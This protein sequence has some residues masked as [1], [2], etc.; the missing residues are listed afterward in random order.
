MKSP[1]KLPGS[2]RFS[3]VRLWLGA[4]L[5]FLG[6][7]LAGAAS[8]IIDDFAYSSTNAARQAWKGSP[9]VTVG[10][11]GQWGN[12][13]VMLL[14]CDFA[15]RASRCFWDRTVSLDLSGYTTFDLQIYAPDPSAISSFTLY[16][17]SGAGWYSGGATL[18]G[19][20]WQTLRFSRSD[21]LTEGT[22]SGWGAIDGIRLSPWKGAG[23]DTYL[24]VRQ[25][26]AFTPPVMIVR[27][28]ES[29]NMEVVD[30]TI[31]RHVT[32]LGGYN[33]DC[34]VVSRAD[35]E[36]GLLNG[37]KLAILPYNENISNLEW[38]NLETFVSGGGKLMVYYL[39]PA[40]MQTL[41]GVRS[42]GWTPGDYAAWVF[43]DPSIAGLPSRVEQASWNITR[44]APN[45]TLNSRVTALWYNSNG[46]STG[47]AAWLTS[48]HGFFCTHVL[49]GDDVDQKS[50]ALLCLISH[51]L[52]E[53]WK[54]AASGAIAEI[55]KVGPYQTYLEASGDIRQNA[56]RRLRERP[57]AEQ[58]SLVTSRLGAALSFEASTNY[59]AAIKAAKEARAALREA[60]YLSLR[61][62]APEFRA[63]WEHHATGPYP[64][65]WPAAIENLATNGFTAV[66]PNMLWGGLAHYASAV[67]PRSTEF[68]NYGDQIAACVNA[69]HARGVE[70]HV[71]KVNWN[72]SGAPQSFIN[73]LRAA[74]RTQVSRDGSDIDWLCPSHP[75]NQALELASMLEVVRNYDVDG[76]H[77]DYIR[78]PDSTACYCPGCR[79]RFQ[80]Q[81]GLAVTNW[82]QD[83]LAS[84]SLRTTFLN[85]RRQQITHLVASVHAQAK[86]AK[87]NVKISAAVFP[88]A[89][90]A[91][92]EVGQDWRTWIDQGLV[93]FLCP[94][95]YTTS[96]AGFTNLVSQQLG[97]AAGRI[98]VY[99]GI[100]AFILDTDGTLVQIQETRKFKTGGF[101]LF[102]LSASSAAN[103]LP[104]ISEGATASEDSDGDNDF[105]PDTWEI[106]W[107]G[108]LNTTAGSMDTDGDGA[109]D[110]QEY[111]A[112]TI[113]T[114]RT[115]ILKVSTRIVT[116]TGEVEVIPALR[117]AS[118]VGYQNARR[119]FQLEEAA[120]AG[121]AWSVVNGFQDEIVTS[122]IPHV[123]RVMP[124]QGTAKFYR[125]RT[126]LQQ[127]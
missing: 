89:N 12:E 119:H 115:D 55:G 81:S 118:G 103:L 95:D 93:D 125:V 58:L 47:Q 38:T 7:G 64:G 109:S 29:S 51:F 45:G 87:P 77:F 43:N 13:L 32:W 52:P 22:P 17:R 117:P 9:S 79:T 113:P 114:N 100:G 60:Y 105:L 40:R 42:L 112:G 59:P 97:Y 20:G 66:F 104:K 116:E 30:Q 4:C 73:S 99:P 39:L 23:R 84:G 94:M 5:L 63:I 110:W 106:R 19:S 33:I 69:A 83:V 50:Y 31:E 1:Q 28:H 8:V 21:F 57:V 78:Y 26:R 127:P 96:L 102:E 108:N 91:Y 121:G 6:I 14:P 75:D 72:L 68:T 82:P 111:V 48:D 120:N 16:F 80:A 37:G 44:A 15:T 35:V 34:G 101:I 61:P 54:E 107:F 70:V 85:W 65:N 27:D 10:N 49:L 124:L 76:I 74:S 18:S 92:D 25:L 90:S 56:S 24:A 36:A 53:V 123:L 67:L 88:N 3:H 98:P 86:A 126:W 11:Q 2:L 62:V 71:W 122:E 46:V 41:L